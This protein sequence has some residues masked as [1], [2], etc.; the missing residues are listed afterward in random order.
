MVAG[1]SLDAPVRAEEMA[2]LRSV[3]E[4]R[5]DAELSLAAVYYRAI[6]PPDVQLDQLEE[7]VPMARLRSLLVIL[8]I[9]GLLLGTVSILRGRGTAVLACLAFGCLPP[10][11][12]EGARIRP[13]LPSTLFAILGLMFLVSMPLQLR[14]QRGWSL[15]LRAGAFALV[16]GSSLALAIATVPQYGVYLLIP[17]TAMI[18]VVLLQLWACLSCLQ[19]RGMTRWPARAMS[20]RIGPWV[21]V[22]FA[23]L[24]FAAM[25]LTTEAQGEAP[26]TSTTGLLFSSC[27]LRWPV[28]LLAGFAASSLL[29]ESGSALGRGRRIRG[30][31]VI[32]LY[33]IG[34]LLHRWQISEE[35][36]D[37][38]PAAPA[39][40][41]LLAEGLRVLLYSLARQRRSGG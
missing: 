22:S 27:W 23:T 40:A 10:I 34:L 14:L 28:L 9:S 18:L 6:L 36:L 33:A 26:S 35:D 37:A 31:E 38:L 5:D 41:I 7:A 24:F 1:V 4:Y 8:L 20:A 17:G 15:V 21:L 32:F 12:V 30:Q 11:A 16:V 25:F 39:L 2:Q 13:E 29:F 3:V 19:R